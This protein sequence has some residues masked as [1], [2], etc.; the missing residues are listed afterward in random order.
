[1]LPPAKA[2]PVPPEPQDEVGPRE[3][4]IAADRRVSAEDAVTS[5]QGAGV[6]GG[7]DSG[8][9][10]A[11]GD[12]ASAG[13]HS[14]GSQPLANGAAFPDHQAPAGAGQSGPSSS[15]GP[16][17]SRDL[18]LRSTPAGD[19]FFEGGWQYPSSALQEMQ[20]LEEAQRRSLDDRLAQSNSDS[21]PE[22]QGDCST[23]GC[24]FSL[25]AW[26]SHFCVNCDLEFCYSCSWQC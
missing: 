24:P 12:P 11:P 26:G 3:R 25:D 21:E 15:S 7:A 5:S 4:N 2:L 9:V 20:M 13:V 18:G 14:A 23:W 10:G 16:R 17:R 19:L 6:S 8:G 1:M 22:I